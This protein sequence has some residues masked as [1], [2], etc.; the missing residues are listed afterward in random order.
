[1]EIRMMDEPCECGNWCDMCMENE[2]CFC[3]IKKTGKFTTC[4]KCEPQVLEYMK[5]F[6]RQLSLE[7]FL[8]VA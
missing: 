5:S 8:G 1:M 4:S 6:S 7:K 2:C 3:R